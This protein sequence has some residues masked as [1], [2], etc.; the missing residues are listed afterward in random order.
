[1][2]R[3]GLDAGPPR[4]LFQEKLLQ[5]TCDE[6]IWPCGEGFGY[7]TRERLLM[8]PIVERR[9]TAMMKAYLDS[10][11]ESENA[12]RLLK[13]HDPIGRVG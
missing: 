4:R 1:M 10:Q 2:H 13:A 12:E 3:C 11:S 7:V 6:E 8:K 9:R 5:R